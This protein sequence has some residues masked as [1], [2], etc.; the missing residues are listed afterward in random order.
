V[1]WQQDRKDLFYPY[2]K[3][4]TPTLG[5]Q[6]WQSVCVNR[7]LSCGEAL[8]LSTLGPKDGER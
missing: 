7:W 1:A 4:Y 5:E 3:T 2:G 6:D 8:G